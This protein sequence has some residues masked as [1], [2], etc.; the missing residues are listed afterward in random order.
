ME[1]TQ[2]TKASEINR[3]LLLLVARPRVGWEREFE[4][5]IRRELERRGVPV[6]D[7]SG[8]LAERDER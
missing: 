3:L 5:L 2:D 8:E 6:P 4:A 7:R 1:R